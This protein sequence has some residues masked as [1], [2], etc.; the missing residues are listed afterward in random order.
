MAPDM[1]GVI[2]GLFAGLLVPQVEIA[3]R[4]ARVQ[5][6]M[7]T[8]GLDAV[9]VLQNAD[10]FYFTGTIADG[11]LAIPAAGEPL[12]LVRR[13]A[14]RARI[15][16][17]LEAIV[18]VESPR[19]YPALLAA[20]GIGPLRRVGLEM[21]VLP[22]LHYLRYVRAFPAAE[23]LDASPLIRAVR[24]VKRPWEIEMMRRAAAIQDRVFRRLAEVLRPDLTELDLVVELE[25][26]ARLAGH[27]G[28]IR[29][30]RFNQDVFMGHLLVGEAA[31]VPSFIDAPAG[32]IG[33]GP[34]LGNGA[35][36]RPVGA[37]EPVLLDFNGCYNGYNSD[38]TRTLAVGGL[39]EDMVRAYAACRQILAEAGRLLRPGVTAGW[40]YDR[41]VAIAR[42]LG[43]AE[44]FMGHGAARAPYVGHGVG[45]EI[46]E[47]PPLASGVEM[48]LE[49]GM[50]LALE[51]K[52]VFPG[53]GV[54]GVEDTFLVEE[55]GPVPLTVS[56]R[57]LTIV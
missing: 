3:H 44:T 43:Y 10:L 18:G 53:R 1:P 46:D 42:D 49:A 2:R 4:T 41:C 26:A 17:P 55:G 32:G 7:Q 21:D 14:E 39:P 19:E 27:Q 47:V 29:F 34:A 25:A 28:L 12:F 15:E 24:A 23:F 50:T 16:S 45:V 5:R 8:R 9:F 40:V 11:L 33:V 35:S 22:A 52:I 37:R 36:R 56:P 13:S 30:R 38:Q 51:P 6:A 54:V 20:H 48:L 57:E 31:S